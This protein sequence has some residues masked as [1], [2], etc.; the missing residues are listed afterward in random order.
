[1]SGS[2]GNSTPLVPCT[3]EHFKGVEDQL[4]IMQ[5]GESGSLLCPEDPS[6]LKLKN[7][8][9]AGYNQDALVA[10]LIF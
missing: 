6:K 7:S 8:Y 4:E 5:G 1:M 3:K 9:K 2:G 10:G